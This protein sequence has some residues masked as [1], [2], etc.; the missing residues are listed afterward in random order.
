M[1]RHFGNGGK[2][3][4]LHL[5]YNQ[6]KLNFNLISVTQQSDC[7]HLLYVAENWCLNQTDLCKA[8]D[9]DQSLIML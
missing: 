1:S 3:K 9:T 5:I 4:S 8:S 6:L 7:K 2:E